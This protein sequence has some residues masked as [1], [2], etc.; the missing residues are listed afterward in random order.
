MNLLT[1]TIIVYALVALSLGVVVWW[2]LDQILLSRTRY[3]IAITNGRGELH[4][5]I[6][7]T[8]RRR[9][10]SPSREIF[11][12]M[13]EFTSAV[14]NATAGSVIVVPAL[15]ASNYYVTVEWK[16]STIL[17]LTE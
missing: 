10:Y 16:E 14:T 12:A 9:R 4:A 17:T 8:P 2:V 15:L 1:Q 5:V 11:S 6:H 7:F 3:N 13:R